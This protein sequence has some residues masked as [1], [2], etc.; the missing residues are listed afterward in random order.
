MLLNRYAHLF[1]VGYWEGYAEVER[2]VEEHLGGST[3]LSH[4]G[5]KDNFF[6]INFGFNESH[7][8]LPHQLKT[9]ARGAMPASLTPRLPIC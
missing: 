6:K 5:D 8:K 7:A 4:G 9:H 3:R 2:I 1:E